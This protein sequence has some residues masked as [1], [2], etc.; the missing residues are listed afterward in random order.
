[1]D[2]SVV[3]EI[4]HAH[5]YLFEVLDN[6]CLFKWPKLTQQL[7]N[8]APWQVESEQKTKANNG[9]HTTTSRLQA[10]THREGTCIPAIHSMK[11]LKCPWTCTAPRHRTTL[12]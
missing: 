11:M 2:D 6:D 7:V 3:V 12:G 5:H 4:G 8:G 10:R 9:S 1:M